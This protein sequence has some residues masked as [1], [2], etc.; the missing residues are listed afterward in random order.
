[1]RITFLLP[2]YPWQPSGGYAV[3]YRYADLLVARGHEVRVLH[4]RRLP[5]GG[6]PAP[7]GLRGRLRR[8]AGALRDLAFRPRAEW[9]KPD[10]RVL[11]LHVPELSRH[12][13]PDGDAVIAT[14]WSTAE[15]VL[16]LPPSKGRRYHLIQGFES[17]HG[18]EERIAAVW[19]A[20]LHKIVIA[21]WLVERGRELGVPDSLMT[22][23]PIAIPGDVFRTTAPV[24]RRPPR[25]AMLHARTPF[26]GAATGLEIMERARDRVP[27][28]EAILFGTEP[29][30]RL[31]AWVR[32]V[33]R[34]TPQHLAEAVYNRSA[35]YLC[36]SMS[37]GW[38]LPP[39][40]AMACGC[41][42][43]SS[44]IGGVRDYAIHGRTALLYPPGDAAAGAAQLTAVLT[45]PELRISLAARGREMIGAFSWSRSVAALEELLGSGTS[46][47]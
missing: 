46:A 15:A 24:E 6:W 4:P 14:W 33:R 12:T 43:V 27:E 20:P 34:A 37:E 18:S 11:M 38:H 29:P 23:I 9:A 7:S 3:V 42:L 31:P 26:K 45:D 47:V 35:V 13:V 30:P 17:W 21:R 5:P 8:G 16:A 22:H 41:A 10:P 25:V 44:D 1:M 28:L 2:R 40:E 19:R 36:A 32:Y 39:A